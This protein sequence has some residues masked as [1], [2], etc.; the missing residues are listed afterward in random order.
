[1]KCPKSNG[2]DQRSLRS[3]TAALSYAW[4]PFSWSSSTYSPD[5]QVAVFARNLRLLTWGAKV[6][7][8]ASENLLACSLCSMTVVTTLFCITPRPG[9]QALRV[10]SRIASRWPEEDTR[11][12]S[13]TCHRNGGSERASN[14]S[15]VI[16]LSSARS[17]I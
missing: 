13:P 17:R 1:M 11:S 16:L 2:I 9:C 8:G 10:T 3:H 15:V 12:V 4:S 14:L 7:L 6:G 5:F